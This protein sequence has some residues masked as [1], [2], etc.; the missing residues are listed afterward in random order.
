MM[1]S[2][3]TLT[4]LLIVFILIAVLYLL[5]FD[6]NKT[7]PDDMSNQVTYV[8]GRPP[9]WNHDINYYHHYYPERHWRRHH[10]RHRR[11]H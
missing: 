1:N 2:N 7:S 4:N 5:F 11:R 3:L 8:Y 9:Y 10:R 6:D